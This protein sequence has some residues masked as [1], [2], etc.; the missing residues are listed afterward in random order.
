M[1]AAVPSL[2]MTA[3]R[4]TSAVA[5]EV[6]GEIFGIAGRASELPSERDQN[7]RIITADGSR[8]V[9]K[10]AN[11]AE[12]REM[13]DAENACMRHLGTSGL[14][15][16]PVS[17]LNGGDVVQS[18]GH[19]VRLI[20]WIEG[21]T[22]GDTTRHSEVL[23]NDL[24]RSLGVIDR[25]LAS[26][27]HYA[28]HRE[29]HW[30]LASAPALVEQQLAT[31]HHGP[32]RHAI[33]T[34]LAVHR[35]AVAPVLS[36]LRRSVIHGDVND[37]NVLVDA[38]AQRVAGVVDFGDMVVSHT[39]ND[40]AIAMAYACL[41][42]SD[43]LGA[44]AV[45]AA[46]YHS[47]YPLADDEIA[48]LFGLMGLRLCLSVTVAAAQQAERP[49]NEYLGISQRSIRHTLPMLAAL[50]PRLAHYRLRDACGLT[51]VPHAPRIIDWLQTNRDRIAPLTGH[52]LR[53]A[54]VLGL[55]LSA[56]SPLVAS[57]PAENAAEPFARRVFAAMRDAGAEIGVGGYDEARVIYA[58]DGFA[59]GAV[60]EERRTVHIGIDITLP[61][62]SPLYAP[63]EGVVHGFEDA[64]ARLDYGPVI[65]LR[66]DIPGD[67][68]LAFY[69][70]YG[71]LD[72]QSIEDLSIGRR[73]TAGERFAAI[74]AAPENGDWWPHVHFQ[75]ITDMLDVPCNFNGV[76]PASQRGTWLSLSPDPNLLLGIPTERL[77]AHPTTAA[78]LA[79]RRRHFGA[80]VRL[81]Y[82]KPLQIVRGWMQYVFDETGRTYIDAYNNVPHVGH[83]HPGV[84]AAVAAQLGT[85]NSNTRYLHEVV[86]TYAAE[87]AERLPAPLEVC[88]FTAS[89]SEAN[90]LALR[91]ARAHTGRRDVIVMDA[92]YHGH[93]TALIDISPYKH[94]G[95]GGEGAP[96]WVHTSPIP[97]VYRGA[98]RADDFEAGSKYAHEVRHT[99]DAIH[100][101]GRSVC[102]YIAETCPSVGGQIIPPPGFLSEV[103]RVVR[104]AGGI[105]IADEVQT[106]F[107]RLG[108]HFWAFEA[109][110]VVP[111]IVVLGK[112]MANGYPMGA[113]VTTRTI[114]DSF[115]NGMEFFSTFGGSTAACAAAL[116][117]LRATVSERLQAHALAVGDHLLAG[118]RELQRRHELIGDVRG[119]GLF[120]G[121]ELVRDRER[122]TPAAEE[123]AA[124]V[125]RMRESGVLVGTDGPHHNVVKIRGPLPLTLDDADCVVRAL[126]QSLREQ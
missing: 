54:P 114:A 21:R 24:G 46:G 68:P 124:V 18:E 87:L 27:D 81:S 94:G 28:L 25:A 36:S 96:D 92:A 93:T 103:Y 53:V 43:P 44:A 40:L 98:Y 51:P 119:S 1:K 31:V 99:I 5:E 78:L 77:A 17:A 91:L 9:L 88:F 123:A 41:G 48:V 49:D 42:K 57:N 80:N 90:E 38:A 61:A 89:G 15:P 14:T 97:D 102:A 70:L 39:V 85:L 95:P 115:D 125:N 23:L 111:D 79:L 112:P 84:S 108:H 113:V 11:A 110:H 126:A 4:L 6:A 83:A 120:I 106:G 73:V 7:F 72:R 50:H 107:G 82:A 32:L 55:D 47:V 104:A 20:T 62:G 13:L 29:F 74:G 76:A 8:F 52:D 45:V 10:V 109:Q 12:R 56:G 34:M 100:D 121:V 37:Y 122:L 35:H 16:A 67:R 33:E 118:L 71:H 75:I 101:R 69:T 26:F 19:L 30:D 2:S 66:H 63:L 116:A 105:C 117:T 58:T 64:R 3:P 60:T 86:V 59:S 22:L 65:I